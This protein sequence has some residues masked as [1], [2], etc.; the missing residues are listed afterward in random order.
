MRRKAR[1]GPPVPR[2]EHRKDLPE[3]CEH[4]IPDRHYQI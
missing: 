1:L 3:L 2:Q 4:L